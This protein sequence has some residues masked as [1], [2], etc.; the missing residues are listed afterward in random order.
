MAGCFKAFK[1]SE[2]CRRHVTSVHGHK[3]F[4]LCQMANC[5]RR[6]SRKD[7]LVQHLRS[8]HSLGAQDVT[9]LDTVDPSRN[10]SSNP[11]LLHGGGAAIGSHMP[12]LPAAL[13]FSSPSSASS[14]LRLLLPSTQLSNTLPFS[15]SS[16]RRGFFPGSYIVLPQPLGGDH[17]SSDTRRS[18]PGT[19]PLPPPT[20]SAPSASFT[21]ETLSSLPDPSIIETDPFT[22]EIPAFPFQSYQGA[23]VV[24]PQLSLFNFIQQDSNNRQSLDPMELHQQQQQ[25]LFADDAVFPFPSPARSSLLLSPLTGRPPSQSHTSLPFPPGLF[26]SQRSFASQQR[27]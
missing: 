19:A 10:F 6:F 22:T 4:Y 9:P 11:P 17:L 12:S 16:N 18:R 7:N 8:V 3:A 5:K 14:Q 27:N 26:S 2:H 15:G 23:G 24:S 20:L 1:R 13:S 21:S 25:P